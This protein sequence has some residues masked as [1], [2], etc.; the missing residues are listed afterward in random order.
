MESGEIAKTEA[1]ESV[2][3]AANGGSIYIF[4]Y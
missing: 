1:T 3:D 2:T 4:N